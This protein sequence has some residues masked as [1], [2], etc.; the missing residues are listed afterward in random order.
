MRFNDF[1]RICFQFFVKAVAELRD[2]TVEKEFKAIG[3]VLWKYDVVFFNF[4]VG[5]TASWKWLYNIYIYIYIYIFILLEVVYLMHIFTH[6]WQKWLVDVILYRHEIQICLKLIYLDSIFMLHCGQRIMQ[7]C[8]NSISCVF[9]LIFVAYHI[10]FNLWWR[11][12]HS[13]KLSLTV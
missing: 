2:F 8:F 3:N 7:V 11:H 4:I 12:Q 6:Y 10:T 1:L 13:L 9:L 5:Q